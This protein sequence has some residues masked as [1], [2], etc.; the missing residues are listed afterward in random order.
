MGTRALCEHFLT[1]EH[2]QFSD[3][4]QPTAVLSTT[5]SQQV[6]ICRLRLTSGQSYKRQYVSWMSRS[7]LEA[8]VRLVD[9]KVAPRVVHLV[10]AVAGEGG[11]V[12][13]GLAAPT[14][15]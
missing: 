12:V 13:G 8:T 7:R 5:R 9:V 3:H 2:N 1:A 15:R 4:W 14:W 10:A 6:G 11:A